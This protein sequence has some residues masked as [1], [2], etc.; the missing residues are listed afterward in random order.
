MADA[1]NLTDYLPYML[2]RAGARIAGA[3]TEELREFGITLP[4]WRAMAAL[5]HEDG[6]RLSRLSELTSVDISTLSRQVGA[7]QKLGLVER[8]RAEA[9]GADNRAVSLRL[10]GTGRAMTE[11]I[12]PHALRYEA[13]ALAG[14]SEQEADVLKEMLA[15]LY[16][17]MAALDDAGAETGAA[18]E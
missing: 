10:T 6:Q 13:I 9:P 7:L 16:G 8:R 18:A 2:N 14:F 11:R 4:M 1:L 17:N 3:F 12:I 15:R 5:Y